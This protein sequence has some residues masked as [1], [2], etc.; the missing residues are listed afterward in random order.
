MVDIEGLREVQLEP[1]HIDDACA[2]VDEAG[3]NE[4]AADWLMMMESGRAIGLEDDNGCLIASALTIPYGAEFGWISM[5]L[6][7]ADWQRKGLATGLLNKCIATHEA[8]GLVS[9]LDATP[10]GEKVYEQLGFSHHF[11]IQRWQ[12]DSPESGRF[13][14]HDVRELTPDD[15]NDIIVYDRSIFEGNRSS[16][17]LDIGIRKGAQ[18]WVLENGQGF[19]LSRE[20]RRARQLGPLCAESEADALSLMAAALDHFGEPVF[21]DVPD[22][23]AGLIDMLMQN[24]F[25]PQRPFQRMFKG[26]TNGFGDIARTYALAGPELG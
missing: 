9:I 15:L 7:T 24:G 23:H 2:L 10:A 12:C 8:A 26:E 3:W 13:E 19:L 4:T 1:R 6:V 14:A 5:V 16:V 18:G 20:G 17:L 25:A 11:T 21:I 22:Q